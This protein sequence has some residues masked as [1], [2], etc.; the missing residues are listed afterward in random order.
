MYES[1]GATGVNPEVLVHRALTFDLLPVQQSISRQMETSDSQDG[2][3]YATDGIRSM[4]Y[5]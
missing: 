3:G 2:N 4:R 1:N 5:V